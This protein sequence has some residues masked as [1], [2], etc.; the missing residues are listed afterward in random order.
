MQIPSRSD[1]TGFTLI[2]VMMAM[3]IMSVGLLGLLQSVIVA[4]EHNARNILREEA[5]LIGEEQMSD[6]L[7]D[8]R[9]RGFD[10]VSSTQSFSLVRMIAGGRR[11]FTVTKQPKVLGSDPTNIAVKKLTVSVAW[12]FKNLTTTHVVYTM[13]TR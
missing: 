5:L 13:I 10:T 9:K 7:T 2:E 11:N 12:G 1:S 6:F 4:Y 8:F 3:L